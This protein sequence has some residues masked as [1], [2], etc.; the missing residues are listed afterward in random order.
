MLRQI[1][2]ILLE[3]GFSEETRMKFKEEKVLIRI[4]QAL[5]N[6]LI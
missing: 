4:Y 3:L 6:R 2:E 1:D 5:V